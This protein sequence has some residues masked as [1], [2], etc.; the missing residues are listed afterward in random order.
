MVENAP[1]RATYT[2]LV[3]YLK[4]SA[5]FPSSSS[6]YIMEAFFDFI[7]RTATPCIMASAS[8]PPK[9][10]DLTTPVQHRIVINGPN[11][12]LCP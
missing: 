6:I 12:E 5:N 2:F 11:G 7:Y 3:Y 8:H 4:G 10:A 1:T 9:P